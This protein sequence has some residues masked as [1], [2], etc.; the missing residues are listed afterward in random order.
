MKQETKI[1]IKQKY[2]LLLLL[3][4]LLLTN[5]QW[6]SFLYELLWK[7]DVSNDVPHFLIVGLE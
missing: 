2:L 5:V 1:L 7:M 3:L 4:L 6:K